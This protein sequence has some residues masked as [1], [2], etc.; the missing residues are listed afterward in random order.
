MIDMLFGNGYEALLMSI[1]LIAAI[2]S[3]IYVGLKKLAMRLGG[4]SRGDSRT[5]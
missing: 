1:A 3:G 2:P 4:K 5:G